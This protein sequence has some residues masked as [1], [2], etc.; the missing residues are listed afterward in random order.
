MSTP[1][2]AIERNDGILTL[3]LQ[4]PEKKNALTMAMYGAMREAVLAANDDPE[5]RAIVITGTEDCFTA[6]N[7]LADFQQRAS[8]EPQPN[9]SSGLQMIEALMA[10]E[11]PVIAAVNGLAI[12][13]GTTMLLHCDFVY[14]GRS[15]RFS[16][17]FVDL[18][19]CPEAASSLLLPLI[20]GPR[21][22]AEMLLAGESLD[23]EQALACGLVN[24]VV[25]DAETLARARQQAERMAQKPR[26]SVRL[27]KRLLR[28]F[29]SPAVAET[30]DYERERFAERLRSAEAQAA[31][32]AFFARSKR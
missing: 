23:A 1:D 27:T 3:R 15:A 19:L 12:G 29:W 22:A 20:A 6:G 8:R 24:A 4:R 25:D 32:A 31:F 18:G 11:T 16:T 14:A 10:C 5:I 26:E 30:L 17:P 13:I 2:I 7:D 9:E 28:R 21:R